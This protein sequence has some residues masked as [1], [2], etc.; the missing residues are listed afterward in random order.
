MRTVAAGLATAFLSTTLTSRS[1]GDTG[2]GIGRVGAA[3]EGFAPIEIRL[4]TPNGGLTVAVAGNGGT[5]QVE[6]EVLLEP[7]DFKSVGEVETVDGKP[8][9]NVGLTPA[10]AAKYEQIS[11]E[12]VG[13]TLAIIIDG[14]VVLA[15]KI[16]DPV[17]AEGFLV[18]VNT[19]AEARDLQQKVRQAIGAN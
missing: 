9:F 16:L 13:R 15:P 17:K 8:G 4:V 7:A 11:T 1:S 2:R 14:K 5:R 10:G 12:H 6:R 18:T 19:G 3:A